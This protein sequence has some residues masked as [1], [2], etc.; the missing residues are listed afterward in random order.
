MKT[1]TTTLGSSGA[2]FIKQPSRAAPVRMD[3]ELISGSEI[4]YKS[5]KQ[6]KKINKN[7]ILA[8]VNLISFLE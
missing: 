3:Q 1:Q 5:V 4:F 8:P 7:L 6:T 2:E